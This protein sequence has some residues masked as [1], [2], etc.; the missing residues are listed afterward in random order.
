MLEKGVVYP[1]PRDSE[2][3]RVADLPYRDSTPALTLDIYRPAG[4]KA[5]LPTAVLVH[6]DLRDP[7]A[8][9]DVKDWGQYRSWGELIAATGL[10]AVTF[11]HRSAHGG[12]RMADVVDDIECVLQHIE[13]NGEQLG[14]DPSSLALVAFSMGVPY[15]LRVA[16]DRQ[17]TLRCAVA[18]YGPMDLRGMPWP[19]DA[20]VLA[21][22]SPIHHLCAGRDLPPLFVARAGSD[23]PDLNDSIDSFVAEAL[24]Q[25]IHLDFMNHPHGPHAFDIFDES[26]RS[27]ALIAAALSFL[28]RQLGTAED[29]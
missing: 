21:E 18:F 26:E 13:T 19:V 5:L 15:A 16:F 7:E 14:L 28:Q 6:G 17:A 25:N 1:I 29:T 3:E 11:N 24:R 12:T 2:I 10:A 22:F 9:K 27:R 20:E 8:V 23:D 4:A